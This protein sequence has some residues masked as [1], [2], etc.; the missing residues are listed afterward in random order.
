MSDDKLLECNETELI[1]LGKKQGLGRLRRGMPKE[2][3]VGLIVGEIPVENKH[4][5]DSNY[6]RLQLATFIH[7]P[8]EFPPD[9]KHKG[10]WERVRSQLPGCNGICTKY[11]C[12][13]GRHIKCLLP[14]EDMVHGK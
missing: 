11:D 14:N 2:E 5:S 9:E 3:L 8:S 10:N 1:W 4:L 13:D 6:T 7:N 12:T